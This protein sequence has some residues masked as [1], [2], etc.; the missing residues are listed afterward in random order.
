MDN[1]IRP[2]TP[3][4]R[5]AGASPGHKQLVR[6]HPH[7]INKRL[8]DGGCARSTRRSDDAETPGRQLVD[9]ARSPISPT[10]PTIRGSSHSGRQAPGTLP[11]GDGPATRPRDPPPRPQTVGAYADGGA[12]V[13]VSRSTSAKMLR[14]G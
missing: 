1:A 14:S 10:A 8:R 9:P 13:M 4:S 3:A 7:P 11:A 2:D 6:S 5:T 12:T